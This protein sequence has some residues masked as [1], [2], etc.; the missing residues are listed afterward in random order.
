MA[1]PPD[2][3]FVFDLHGD[4][5]WNG[6]PYFDTR[7]EALAEGRA[8]YPDREIW[9][10]RVG[11]V[12]T[13]RLTRLA[14]D[15][16]SLLERLSEVAYEDAGEAAECWP[17]LTEKEKVDLERK[18]SKA[19][20]DFIGPPPFWMAEDPL[21]HPPEMSARAEGGEGQGAPASRPRPHSR[22]ESS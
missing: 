19:L 15:I 3:S 22:E 6:S 2:G 8:L 1:Q 5:V 20:A 9:T 10:A 11:S 14:I 18:L 12:H 13:E 7:E 21:P 17:D 4:G 16:D